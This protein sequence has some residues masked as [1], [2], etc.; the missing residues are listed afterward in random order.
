MLCSPSLVS[1]K[2]N[3]CPLLPSLPT[4]RAV[5][6]PAALVCKNL[7]DI[8]LHHRVALCISGLISTLSVYLLLSLLFT[9]LFLVN[10][11]YK[12][13]SNWPSSAVQVLK[14]WYRK[15]AA[16]T[17]VLQSCTCSVLTVLNHIKVL[18]LVRVLVY[19]ALHI[20]CCLRFCWSNFL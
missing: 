17:T 9:L 2:Q 7:T 18:N 16:T 6:T 3:G 11:H 13:L 12:F 1:R 20:S 19:S 4:I 8:I 10:I 14:M 15:A 5:Y